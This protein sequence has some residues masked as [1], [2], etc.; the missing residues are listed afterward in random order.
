[1]IWDS[2]VRGRADGSLVR[3]TGPGADINLD[4]EKQVEFMTALMPVLGDFLPE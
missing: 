3:I 1:M 2:L 4:I